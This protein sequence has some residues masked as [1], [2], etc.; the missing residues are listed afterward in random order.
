MKNLIRVNHSDVSGAYTLWTLLAA[1]LAAPSIAGL[2]WFGSF[3]KVGYCIAAS[4]CAIYITAGVLY[5]T[6]AML[7]SVAARFRGE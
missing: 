3:S 2:D 5:L 7:N 1:I 4:L 6:Q